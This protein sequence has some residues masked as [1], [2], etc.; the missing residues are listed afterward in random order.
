MFA[1]SDISKVNKDEKI[2]LLIKFT[3]AYKE[4]INKL[5]ELSSKLKQ[6][7]NEEIINNQIS[8]CRR[9][10]D[11]MN[12]GIEILS[13][14]KN[15]YDAFSL[16]NRAMLMQRAHSKLAGSEY[17]RFPGESKMPEF[18][19]HNIDKKSASWR[20]F[21][22]AFI[23]MNVESISNPN[24]KAR[25]VVDLIWI[26]TGGGKTEAYLGLTGFAIFLRRLNDPVN[27]GGT[28][29]IMRYTLRLLAAQQFTRA[30]ILICACEK[31]R[32]E[33]K[34][35]N[36][37]KEEISIGL[38]VGG[39]S[40][41]NKD[42]EAK[43]EYKELTKPVSNKEE[44]ESRKLQHNKFQMLKCPW[45]GTKLEVEYVDGKKKGLWG[46][47]FDKKKIIYCPESK[48]DFH[49]K[50][51]IQVVDEELYK[52]P[53]TLLFGTVDKFAALPWKGEVSNLFALNKESRSKSPE[54]IIQDELHLISG[55][56]GTMVGLYETAVDAM[57]SAKGV[58][59]KIVASTATIK[60]AEEQCKMLFD[61]N[62][63]QFPPSGLSIENCFFTREIPIKKKAGKIIYRFNAFRKNCGYNT[64]KAL[65]STFGSF[66]VYRCIRRS[67]G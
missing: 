14:N 23:L 28:A 45:C 65:Y 29:I 22:L 57:C 63:L 2:N 3:N 36:L 64:N 27:G 43:K 39:D 67:F 47:D 26:P 33:S 35:Y 16:M 58:K 52:N 34:Q 11:R 40:T 4:W 6:K 30:S 66:K 17:D 54:L 32:R 1:L 48:C 59:P 46:Y 53:P 5:N 19:Y 13:E 61:R 25:D 51:P 12:K 9:V 44:L 41:P 18:D 20:A 50:L 60:R 7:Y 38:W 49:K 37:G 42:A 15:A 56:L 55:P 24:C 62:V 8:K 10:L 21:Q 31:I